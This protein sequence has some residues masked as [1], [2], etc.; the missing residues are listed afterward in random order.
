[1][2]ERQIKM[3]TTTK[4]KN[5]KSVVSITVNNRRKNVIE[6][7]KQYKIA[8]GI[9]LNKVYLQDCIE[10][11]RLLPSSIIKLITAD[12]PYN[13][14]LKGQYWDKMSPEEF[15]EFNRA[16]LLEAYRVLEEDGAIICFGLHHNIFI[17]A[18]VMRE[19][20]FVIKTQ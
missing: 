8:Q 11:M 18:Q 3:K 9:L 20:G 12:P 2:N 19:I 6:E 1:N 10:G 4:I 15:L 16:W 7:Y 17:V 13:M 5:T 14:K